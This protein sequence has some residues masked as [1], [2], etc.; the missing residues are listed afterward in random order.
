VTTNPIGFNI[1]IPN[2]HYIENFERS[3]QNRKYVTSKVTEVGTDFIVVS[4]ENGA[5][6]TIALHAIAVLT[7]L[8]DLKAEADNEPKK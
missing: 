8:P 5:E 4:S 3:N 1:E 6:K 2:Q 7:K